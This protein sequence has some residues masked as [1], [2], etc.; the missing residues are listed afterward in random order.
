MYGKLFFRAGKCGVCSCR[1]VV[2]MGMKH[3]SRGHGICSR[4]DRELFIKTAEAQ[5]AR[6]LRGESANPRFY[7]QPRS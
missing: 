1:E 4:C 2:V 5:K 6:Y 7:T 3:Y